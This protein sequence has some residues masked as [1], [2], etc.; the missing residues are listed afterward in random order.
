LGHTQ[1]T[2]LN[3]PFISRDS[4]GL[5]RIPESVGYIDPWGWY[6]IQTPAFPQDIIQRAKTLKVVRNGWAGFYFQW[7]IDLVH[8]IETVKG[9]QGYD[10]VPLTGDLN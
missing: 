10:F 1:A 3:A 8:L 5:K 4:Y 6:E 2:E 9:P 7:Y